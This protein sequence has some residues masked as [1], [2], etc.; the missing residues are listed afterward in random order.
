MAETTTKEKL[1][2]ATLEALR[3]KGFAGSS[4][5]TIAGLAGVNPGLIFYYYDTLDALLLAALH[6]T[7]Q[8]RLERWTAAAEQVDSLADLI[9]LLRDIYAEDVASGHVRVVS[10]MVAGSV[11]R[12]ELA[13]PVMA[14]ME[15]WIDL[16]ESCVERALAGSPLLTIPPPRALAMTAVTFY[17]G[18]NLLSHLGSETPAVEELLAAGERAAP[19]LDLLGSGGAKS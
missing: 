13:P 19:L 15:P 11:S 14:E 18:A 2:E 4:A 1:V 9:S 5:R 7:S 12:P 10:E 16:A 17:L 6:H 8:V 3:T